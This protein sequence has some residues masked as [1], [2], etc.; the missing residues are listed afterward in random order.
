MTE[1]LAE[2]SQSPLVHIDP[3]K[4]NTAKVTEIMGYAFAKRHGI[5]CVEVTPD[6]V[7]D[8]H[9]LPIRT[10]LNGEVMQ[11]SNTRHLVFNCYDQI[12]YLTQAFTLLPGD[13]IATGTP[14][15]VGVAKTP[16]LFMKAGDR[17]R[18]ETPSGGGFGKS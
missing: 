11:D 17:V 12:V 7:G 6:E 9:D 4:I 2:K 18:I 8:P 16:P 15:G 3:M 5:L 14:G 13:V 1:W 10:L